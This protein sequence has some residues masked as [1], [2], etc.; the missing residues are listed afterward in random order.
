MICLMDFYIRTLWMRSSPNVWAAARIGCLHLKWDNVKINQ[1]FATFSWTE[2]TNC[3][4]YKRKDL[5]RQS[6]VVFIKDLKSCYQ[7][8]QQLTVVS[9]VSITPILLR[10]EY[11]NCVTRIS[12]R[13]D[14]KGRGKTETFVPDKFRKQKAFTLQ[15]FVFPPCV[16]G[17]PTASYRYFFCCFQWPD[18]WL[19]GTVWRADDVPGRQWNNLKVSF[20]YIITVEHDNWKWSPRIFRFGQLVPLENRWQDHCVAHEIFHHVKWQWRRHWFGKT[21][22]QEQNYG[23]MDLESSLLFVNFTVVHFRDLIVFR[24]PV[25]LEDP[26]ASEAISGLQIAFIHTGGT[27]KTY[28]RELRSGSQ[29]SAGRS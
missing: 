27:N 6:K 23:P 21:E 29:L 19:P 11:N 16:G 1:E 12:M 20:S 28:T 9:V 3:W 14:G 26:F 25:W 10:A 4:G 24:I 18:R 7:Y 2:T 15:A 13:T 8:L 5:K 17:I 22:G